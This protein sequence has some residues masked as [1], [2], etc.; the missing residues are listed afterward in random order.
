[1]ASHDGSTRLEVGSTG[2]Q[3]CSLRPHL[4]VMGLQLP[5]M[6]SFE[7]SSSLEADPA[8]CEA[9]VLAITGAA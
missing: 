2:P 6:D 8:T 4:V 7:G 1:M 9:I 3:S 5:R